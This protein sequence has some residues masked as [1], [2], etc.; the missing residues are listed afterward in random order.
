MLMLLEQYANIGA[1]QNNMHTDTAKTLGRFDLAIFFSVLI[2][3]LFIMQ[4][5]SALPGH[6]LIR[7]E[8]AVFF[9]PH[10]MLM[11]FFP[12]KVDWNNFHWWAVIGKIAV[13]L[14]ASILYGIIVQLLVNKIEVRL[15]RLLK[16]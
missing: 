3:C 15:R 14:P 1:A 13:A 12:P 16:R 5:I 6:G 4:M 7:G 10:T 11:Y 9:L 8:F 2:H